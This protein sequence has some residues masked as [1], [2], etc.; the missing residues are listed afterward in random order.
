LTP[1]ESA[2]VGHD[3]EELEGAHKAGIATVAVN[4]EPGAIADYYA[5]SLVGLLDVPIFKKL[6]P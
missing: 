3:A 5:H 2:F 1:S 4:Y 6:H